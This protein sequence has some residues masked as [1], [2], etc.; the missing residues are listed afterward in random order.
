MGV[1]TYKDCFSKS[2]TFLEDLIVHKLK[3][4]YIIKKIP[5]IDGK[6]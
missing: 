6:T 4:E 3:K 2:N 1:Q 5:L